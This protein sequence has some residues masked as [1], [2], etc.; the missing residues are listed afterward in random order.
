MLWSLFSNVTPTGSDCFKTFMSAIELVQWTR[1]MESPDPYQNCNIGDIS[2]RRSPRHFWL[3]AIQRYDLFGKFR[4]QVCCLTP[5]ELG[6]TSL[7]IFVH[8]QN[9]GPIT[10]TATPRK[11][12]TIQG[13]IATKSEKSTK[14]HQKA[15]EF[16][17]IWKYVKLHGT[18]GVA[19]LQQG[20]NIRKVV[21]QWKLQHFFSFLG[22]VPAKWP[23]GFIF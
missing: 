20:R 6:E 17:E 14:K 15:L 11:T 2:L 21:Q 19:R 8:W 1:S 22:G 23:Y 7:Y 3:V 13:K 9:R 4:V 16:Q 10:K 18:T 12:A 5:S